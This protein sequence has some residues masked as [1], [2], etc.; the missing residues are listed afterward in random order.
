MY[1]NEKVDQDQ[2]ALMVDWHL[3]KAYAPVNILP[4]RGGGGLT[5]GNLAS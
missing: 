4:A 5:Q 3:S 2:S 1:L